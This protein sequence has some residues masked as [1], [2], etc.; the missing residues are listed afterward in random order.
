[1]AFFGNTQVK[2]AEV[3]WVPETRTWEVNSRPTDEEG[4]PGAWASHDGNEGEL[5]VLLSIAHD[6]MTGG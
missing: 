6:V 4:E 5:S 1:M 2:V 3:F